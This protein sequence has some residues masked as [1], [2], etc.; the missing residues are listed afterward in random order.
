MDT[1]ATDTADAAS[2]EVII[3]AQRADQLVRLARGEERPGAERREAVATGE[4][5][6]R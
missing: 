5:V 4:S 6:A 1:T 3:H 2:S